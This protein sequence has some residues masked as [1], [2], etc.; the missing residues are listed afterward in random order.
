MDTDSLVSRKRGL[1][2]QKGQE[3][4]PRDVRRRRSGTVIRHTFSHCVIPSA[5][6]PAAL[7]LNPPA[8]AAM[9]PAKLN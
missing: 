7:K 3:S 5:P 8:G 2:Q 6:F 4:M 1:S 9:L